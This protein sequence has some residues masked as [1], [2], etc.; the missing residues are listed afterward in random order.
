[1]NSLRKSLLYSGSGTC[2]GMILRNLNERRT[3]RHPDS[4][5]SRELGGHK[6]RPTLCRLVRAQFQ[7]NSSSFTTMS[8]TIK[9]TENARFPLPI[10][11]NNGRKGAPDAVPSK[12][13][14]MPSGSSSRSSLAMPKQQA[15]EQWTRTHQHERASKTG[16]RECSIESVPGQEKTVLAHVPLM[17]DRIAGVAA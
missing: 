11:A 1:L 15:Y 2:F 16:R 8:K 17:N 13:R 7:V 4:Q 5:R 6:I 14:A 9:P 12:T 10:R 3:T